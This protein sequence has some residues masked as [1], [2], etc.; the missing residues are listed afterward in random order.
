MSSSELP[1]AS[2][3]PGD[4]LEQEHARVA[5]SPVVEALLR[6]SDIPTVVAD[7]NLQIVAFNDDFLRLARKSDAGL[8]IGLRPGESLGCTF[9][10]TQDGCA[11]STACGSCGLALAAL[12]VKRS[13]DSA[14]RDCFLT[15][16]C[17]ATTEDYA[18]RARAV[19]IDVEGEHYVL[20]S[21]RDVSDRRRNLALDRIFLHDLAN[22]AQA[23]R[24]TVDAL[25]RR[26]VDAEV[27]DTLRTL[28]GQLVAEVDF[29]RQLGAER[30]G[31]LEPELNEQR[32]AEL[33]ERLVAAATHH[34]SSD[35]RRIEASIAPADLAVRT[36]PLLVHH[37]LLNMLVNAL[38]ASSPGDAVRLVVESI[39]EE[40][41]LRVWS[42]PVVPENIRERIFRRYFTTKGSDRGLGCYAMRL[43]GE[44]YLGG[45]VDFTSEKGE[46]TWFSLRVRRDGARL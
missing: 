4:L 14:E 15:T 24:G 38:E 13:R 27:L 17:D 19:P 23:L 36:D 41:V 25:G 1:L 22:Y 39:G 33:V 18:Y 26:D 42:R 12:T 34:P 9:A 44:R 45:Q 40:A 2:R 30:P 8:V 32:V 29:R 5:R 3:T 16:Q 10:Q 21:L 20:I 7:A 28:A 6:A 11:T 43:L 31:S 35:G 46:G 37:V